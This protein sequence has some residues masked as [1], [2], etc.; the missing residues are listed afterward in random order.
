MSLPLNQVIQ[1][2]CL[3]I[4]DTFPSE[5]VDLVVTDPPYGLNK[6]E[7]ENDDNLDMFFMSLPKIYRLL[8]Q[9]SWF[10]TFFS[11]KYL[12]L[13]FR[14]NPFS[15]VWLGT[16]HHINRT[17][18]APSPVGF[19]VQINFVVFKKGSPKIYRQTRDVI[20]QKGG[21]D[22]GGMSSNRYGKQYEVKPLH[23]IMKII[24]CFSKEGDIV[25]DPFLGSGTTAVACKNLNRKYVGIEISQKYFAIAQGRL[26]RIT[27]LLV[28]SEA[29]E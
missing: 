17:F 14:G 12:P 4:M 25:L 27:S 24:E 21:Y 3:E 13:C 22:L 18:K 5:S 15:Y 9:N 28:E 7:I 11:L 29:N 8:K 23:P 1:G 10:I 19:N 2:D 16:I 6:V 26:E 20:I